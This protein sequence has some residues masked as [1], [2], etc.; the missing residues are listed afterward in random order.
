MDAWDVDRL[1]RLAAGLPAE[2][3]ALADLPEIDSGY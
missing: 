3:A 1:A 2:G